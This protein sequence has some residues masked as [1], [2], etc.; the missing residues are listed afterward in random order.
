M[1]PRQIGT[2]RGH[3][4]GKLGDEVQR[5]KDHVSRAIAVGGLQLSLKERLMNVGKQFSF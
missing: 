3:Q 5:L 1:K 4:R 2:G